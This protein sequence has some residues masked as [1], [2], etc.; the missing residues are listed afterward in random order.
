MQISKHLT[1]TELTRSQT[2]TRLGINNTAPMHVIENL[3]LVAEKVF[4]PI[5]TH[6]KKPIRISSGYRSIALN[7]AIGGSKNSQHVNGQA[8]DMQG[9]NGLTNAQIFNYV[10]DNLEFDQLIWEFGTKT[11]PAWV[12]V[13][14]SR[15]RNRK[16]ILYVGLNNQ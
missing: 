11:E 2:A 12:H 10:K 16:Q 6:F 14:F 4:E 7:T 3:K 13:S 9:M 1:L 15:I 5:R 8:L